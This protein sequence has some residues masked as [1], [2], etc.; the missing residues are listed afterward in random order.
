MKTGTMMGCIV[1]TRK[2]EKDLNVFVSKLNPMAITAVAEALE[3]I[4]LKAMENLNYDLE[5]GHGVRL[6]AEEQSIEN[7]KVIETSIEGNGIKGSLTYTSPHAQLIEYGGSYVYHR[8]PELGPMPIGAQEGHLPPDY[9]GYNINANFQGKFFLTN[10]FISEE[11]VVR[12]II[13]GYTDNLIT[14]CFSR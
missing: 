12:E 10:A 6:G 13:Q 2:L 1:D 14:S 8:N 7:T 5:W 9:F 3:H 11:E 4:H